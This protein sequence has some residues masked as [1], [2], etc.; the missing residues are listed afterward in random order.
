MGKKLL[1]ALTL[2]GKFAG[3][4]LQNIDDDDDMLASMARELVEKN[5]IGDSAD[6]IWKTLHQEHQRLFG[7][8]QPAPETVAPENTVED[9]SQAL[10]ESA[11]NMQPVL[12]FG[13][14]PES[15]KSSRRRSR[16]ITP[17]QPSLFGW[18]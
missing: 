8:R 9:A 6:A 3:E 18:N 15:L 16:Q 2:E 12:V 10:I 1:V 7:T 4:G 13:N 5:R 11:I 14:R 17:E